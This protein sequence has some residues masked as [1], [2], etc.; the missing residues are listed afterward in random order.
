M[1]C[2]YKMFLD[3]KVHTTDKIS[4]TANPDYNHKQLFRF[5]P[6]TKQAWKKIMA[7]GA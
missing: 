2:T 6:A 1:H 7:D 3:E 5:N 4:L